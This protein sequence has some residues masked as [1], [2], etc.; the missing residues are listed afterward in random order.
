MI[1]LVILPG[2]VRNGGA[3]MEAGRAMK[4]SKAEIKWGNNHG[5]SEESEER[6]SLIVGLRRFLTNLVCIIF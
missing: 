4:K 5:K 6:M 1:I 3:G 2:T